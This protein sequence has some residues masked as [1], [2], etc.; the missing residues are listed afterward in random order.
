VS[1]KPDAVLIVDDDGLI[2]ETLRRLLSRK[3]RVFV[4]L[5]A[6]EARVVLDTEEI[7]V[8]IADQRMPVESG[9]QL[10]TW[11]CENHPD[12]MR[13][14]LTGYTDLPTIIQAVN[15]G[16]IWHYIQKPWSN[17]Y[18]T[19]LVQRAIEFR[20][21]DLQM[22]R[23]FQG[24]I[25]SLVVALEA[26]HPYTSGH[27][28]RVT[29]LSGLLC[30][31]LGL[32]GREA[33]DILLAAQLHDIGKLGVDNRYLDK[34]GD[35]DETEWVEV[36]RHVS[37]GAKILSET[38]FLETILP[39]VASHHERYDGTGYPAGLKGGQIP[40]GGRIIALADAFDAMTSDRAYR[41][42]L[43]REH[44]IRELRGGAGRHFDPTLADLFCRHLPGD[45]HL[46]P[47]GGL[48]FLSEGPGRRTTRR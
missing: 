3:W 1:E 20:D 31:A 43:A 36:R 29:R 21:K 46:V 17:A 22:R 41:K 47:G 35:L 37:V 45:I 9:V 18:V 11:C 7:A 23:Q 32:P 27:S 40:L 8:V 6:A 13:I 33:Q 14:L 48:A 24:A 44:A 16:G 19:T 4:A 26:S 28:T 5:S 15:E 39:M 42:A 25:R 34:A 2:L 10:L 30:D 12:I 38:G